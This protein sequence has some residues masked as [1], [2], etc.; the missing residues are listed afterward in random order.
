MNTKDLVKLNEQYFLD[1]KDGKLIK[2]EDVLAMQDQSLSF[3]GEIE[4][5][6]GIDS[7]VIN[8]NLKDVSGYL[9]NSGFLVEVYLSGADGKIKKLEKEDINGPSG[10]DLLTEGYEKYL[11]IEVDVD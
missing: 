3:S 6:N 4:T 5:I 11:S 2:K 7:H 8:V 9:S 1:T 10:D